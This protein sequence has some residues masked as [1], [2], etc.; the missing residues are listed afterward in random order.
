MSPEKEKSF[1][2]HLYNLP[3]DLKVKIFQMSVQS[4]ME[5][6]F[7]DHGKNFRTTLGRI[8]CATNHGYTDLKGDHKDGF[9]VFHDQYDQHMF[10][11]ADNEDDRY[12]M[13]STLCDRL[14]GYD[15]VYLPRHF[16]NNGFWKREWRDKPDYYWYSEHCRC[17]RCDQVKDSKL[18]YE[19]CKKTQ[20]SK[21]LQERCTRILEGCSMATTPQRFMVE[22]AIELVDNHYMNDPE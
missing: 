19:T 1:D 4:N 10:A 18:K 11:L 22:R 7:Q 21:L 14:E 17:S 15:E 3:L 2:I 6:W 20:R 12:F 13:H 8:D 5:R 9:W 16:D